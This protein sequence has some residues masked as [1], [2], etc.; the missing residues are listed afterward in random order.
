MV[1]GLSQ[2]SFWSLSGLSGLSFSLCGAARWLQLQLQLQLG[3]DQ[4][5]TLILV[6]WWQTDTDGRATGKGNGQQ[7][8]KTQDG[9]VRPRC[10]SGSVAVLSVG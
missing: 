10:S 5:L 1:S 4:T 8:R 3:K 9:T 7:K 6:D 2:V